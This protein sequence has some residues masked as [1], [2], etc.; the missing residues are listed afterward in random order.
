MI[1][2]SELMTPG[3]L[4]ELKVFLQ[5]G[6]FSLVAGGTDWFVSKGRIL[7]DGTRLIDLSGVSELRGILM[8]DGILRVGSG[9]TM[10]SVS[11][12]FLV[13]RYASCLAEAASDVGSWQIRNRATL[14]GNLAG[15]SPA[16]DT[17]P[18][19]LALGASVEVL[20][21]CGISERP[22]SEI[23]S[24]GKKGI[25][26]DEVITALLIPVSDN[27]L[28]VSAYG[29]IGSRKEVSI[30]RLSLAVNVVYDDVKSCFKDALVVLG[31]LGSAGLRCPEAEN[32]LTFSFDVER[33][34]ADF[35]SALALSVDRAI[36]GRSTQLYKRTAVQALGED[37]LASLRDK[38]GFYFKGVKI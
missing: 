2:K 36:P 24:K 12:D 30:A 28:K 8:K 13:R 10:T 19:L 6:N 29:K 22:V 15:G 9:E 3:S 37:V 1:Q 38:A 14:G 33:Q 16:A 31:T 5:V 7:P 35:C 32:A 18:A 21:V 34:R 17:P 23:I 11:N 27:E 4:A 25:A 20:S 26:A